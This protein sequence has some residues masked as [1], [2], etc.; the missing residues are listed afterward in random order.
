[1]SHEPLAPRFRK[2]TPGRS[3]RIPREGAE[4]QRKQRP[5]RVVA[6]T[7]ASRDRSASAAASSARS[8]NSQRPT[9]I[10][11]TA[12]G[13]RHASSHSTARA[14]RTSTDGPLEPYWRKPPF[15]AIHRASSRFQNQ[16]SVR[17][18]ASNAPA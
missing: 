15:A 13:L 18:N 17:R 7:R 5:E 10:H 9:K 8:R 12:A 6:T 11:S 2:R 1:V 4:P 3:R 14:G 16:S